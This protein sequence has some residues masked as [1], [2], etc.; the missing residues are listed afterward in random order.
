MRV[1]SYDQS[2]RLSFRP[3]SLVRSIP[4]LPLAQSDSYLTHR[5]PLGSGCAM[6]LNHVFRSYVKVIAELYIKSLSRGIS[7]LPLVQYGSYFTECLV[8]GYAV[9]L[10]DVC[11]SRSYQTMQNFFFQSI[12]I[13]SYKPYL[14]HTS[15]IKE[16]F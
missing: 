3:R 12:Y 2:V 1:P 10:N 8:K 15:H 9:T 6:A 4:S 7:F 14:S 11:R 16:S 13:L 5:M